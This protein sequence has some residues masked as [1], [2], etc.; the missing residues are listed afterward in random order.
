MRGAWVVV[1]LICAVYVVADGEQKPAARKI[2][3][4]GAQPMPIQGAAADKPTD[5]QESA[6]L[7][8]RR[9]QAQ[10]PEVAE[11]KAAAKKRRRAAQPREGQQ[12]LRGE[13]PQDQGAKNEQP[14]LATKENAEQQSQANLRQQQTKTPQQVRKQAKQSQVV[15]SKFGRNKHKGKGC[16]D[17]SVSHHRRFLGSDLMELGKSI[18][19]FTPNFQTCCERCVHHETCKGFT[20]IAHHHRCVLKDSGLT[21]GNYTTRLDGTA[22]SGIRTGSLRTE[23]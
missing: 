9:A 4:G 23:L 16:A 21:A 2:R 11:A 15:L 19:L 5:A 12:Q 17:F 18:K 22:V 13:A 14:P 6:S 1:A 8:K 3:R 20:F 10:A 7:R